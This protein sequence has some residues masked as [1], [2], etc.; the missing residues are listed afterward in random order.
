M[1][2]EALLKNFEKQRIFCEKKSHSAEKPEGDFLLLKRIALTELSKIEGGPY[3][4]K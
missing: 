3:D 2:K 1:P 4:L